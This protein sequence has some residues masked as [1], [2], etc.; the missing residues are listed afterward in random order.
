[1]NR[2][3]EVVNT[4]NTTSLRIVTSV[5][6]AAMLLIMLGFGVLFFGFVPTPQQMTL[7]Y[8]M[9][10]LLAAMMALDVAQFVGKR[11][12]DAGLAAA[13][14][15][16]QPSPVTV[17]GPSTVNVDATPPVDAAPPTVTPAEPTNPV[18]WKDG[19]DTGT[20]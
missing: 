8:A 17:G 5:F 1:M 3:I 13:K 4:I 18:Q 14:N 20:I 12:S 19:K 11:F 2:V 7:L 15:P 6:V 9:G 16:V 10:G